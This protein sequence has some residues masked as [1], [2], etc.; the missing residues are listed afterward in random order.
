[1][2]FSNDEANPRL[3]D[4]PSTQEQ[5]TRPSVELRSPQGPRLQKKRSDAGRATDRRPQTYAPTSTIT[6]REGNKAR[7]GSIR[8]A[9]RRVFGRR[10]REAEPEQEPPPRSSPGHGYHRSEPT[11]LAPQPEVP[12]ADVDDDALIQRT[13]S[14]PVVPITSNVQRTRSPYAVEFPRSARLKPINLGSPFNAP[15][16]TLRRRKTLPSVL[17]SDS[18]AA[19]VQ[20]SIQ[21]PDDVGDAPRISQEPPSSEIG[22]ALRSPESERRKSRSADDLRLAQVNTS[23][24]SRKRSEEIQFWRESIQ[25][26]VLRASGFKAHGPQIGEAEEH[27]EDKTPMADIADPFVSAAEPSGL[28]PPMRRPQDVSPSALGTELS[29][30]LEDRVARLEAGLGSFRRELAQLAADRNRRTIL[31]GNTGLS[32]RPRRASSGSRTASMLAETLASDLEPSSYQ[33][34]YTGGARPSTSPEPPRTPT[35]FADP[36]AAV[37]AMPVFQRTSEEHYRTPSP[38]VAPAPA[39]AANGNNGNGSNRGQTPQ[40]TFRSLYE[41]LTDERS[42]RRRLEAQMRG[43]RDEISNLH[44]QVS[45]QSNVQSQRSSYYAQGSNRLQALLRETEDSPPGTG[46]Q[47]RSS[48]TTGLSA[49][50]QRVVSRFSGTE[51]ESGTGDLQTPYE[52]YQTPVEEHGQFPFGEQRRGEG[53]MF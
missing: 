23:R 38:P 24:L 22:R 30:D 9:I 40:Y 4:V 11:P 35:R 50:Q 32:T 3:Q 33:Y 53:D 15:G 16:S 21:S 42:A 36:S 51:S 17:I 18:E 28:S 20:A 45:L 25:G 41:M 29:Q 8:N 12:E 27:E 34:Q 1:M 47:Q 14:V 52:A 46:V 44:Y 37:P 49:E 48:G 39:P 6:G 10:S 43:L 7:K 13:F 26:G 19:A 31:I 5:E 2:D